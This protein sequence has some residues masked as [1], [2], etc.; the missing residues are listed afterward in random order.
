[1]S[2]LC[3]RVRKEFPSLLPLLNLG[4][5]PNTAFSRYHALEWFL[6]A[7]KSLLPLRSS[8]TKLKT[9]LCMLR[10]RTPLPDSC[11][12]LLETNTSTHFLG[13]D[14]IQRKKKKIHPGHTYSA[15]ENEPWKPK[16]LAGCTVLSLGFKTS[17]MW[18][19][20]GN[21]LSLSCNSFSCT[22]HCVLGS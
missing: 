10:V 2:W 20:E 5:I 15:S 1:M 4:F 21:S 14:R 8:N 22:T 3:P 6:A 18:L 7:G 17:G 13:K 19:Q 11:H 12:Q 9:K 16:E